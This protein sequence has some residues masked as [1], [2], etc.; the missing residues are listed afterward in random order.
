VAA[1]ITGSEAVKY[2]SF[3]NPVSLRCI[4]LLSSLASIAV[5][6]VPV[7]RLAK[8]EINLG[9]KDGGPRAGES[10]GVQ[11]IQA[12]LVVLQ[13]ALAV[14][15][16]AGT[17]LMVRSFEKLSRVDLGFD[18]V[19]K[20]KVTVTFPQGYNPAPEVR[21]QLFA[22]LQQRLSALP[23]VRDVSFG[24]DSLLTGEFS[25]GEQLLMPD[26]TYRFAACSFV[27]AKFLETAGMVMKKGRW[28]SG[29]QGE[30][31]VVINETFA[32]AR[33]GDEDPIGKPFKLLGWG[34]TVLSVVGVVGNIRDS[35]R[36]VPGM[37]FYC[38]IWA[39]PQAISSLLL[40]L[41]RDPGKTFAGLV[42]HAIYDFDPKLI[43]SQVSSIDEIVGNGMWAERYAFKIMRGLATIALG[44]AIVGLFSVLTYTI[45]CRMREFGVR[46][47]L[48]AQP[49]DLHRLVLKRGL[50]TAAIGV[51][52]GTAGALGLTRFMQSLLFETTPYDPL[53]YMA[54][55]IVLLAAAAAACWHPAR[56]AAQVDIT[57]LLRAE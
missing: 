30:F 36:S 18:P 1:L 34:D 31:E 40:R 44:L 46:L 37:R 52:V 48:G 50:T 11:R 9:L 23:S 24:Q 41:D 19:G 47:A 33:F 49:A 15:L 45:H 25:G 10:R 57:Q 2:V 16:L 22:R 26:G 35:V 4:F 42:R 27:G 53:V 13:A 7:W 55:G 28:L 6:V 56:R 21:L 29:R 12:S 38:P 17:G 54:V 51:V 3:W 32:K 8:S 14:M 5:V 43:V 20:V 39:Y